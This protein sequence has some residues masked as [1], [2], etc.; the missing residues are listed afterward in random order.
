MI[1]NIGT[2]YP[3]ETR[4]T[5][6]YSFFIVRYLSRRRCEELSCLESAC[7]AIKFIIFTIRLGGT[8]KHFPGAVPRDSRMA[9]LFADN[10]GCPAEIICDCTKWPSVAV[11]SRKRKDPR[12]V[13]EEPVT[14]LYG[15]KISYIV[16]L[17]QCTS[18]VAIKENA[19]TNGPVARLKVSRSY[20]RSPRFRA[21]RNLATKR[22]STKATHRLPRKFCHRSTSL[23]VSFFFLQLIS[24]SFARTGSYPSESP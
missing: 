3:H 14:K 10:G 13:R 21:P 2:P 9:L 24:Q 22:S 5:R 18:P 17:I 15:M 6:V 4:V 1:T 16:H 7:V 23:L 20:P 11:S 8:R 12:S 19:T